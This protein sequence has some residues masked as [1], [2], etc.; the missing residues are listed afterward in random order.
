M[1]RKGFNLT[2]GK[3]GCSIEQEP[4]IPKVSDMAHMLVQ[5]YQAKVL[6]VALCLVKTGECAAEIAIA[7]D[8]AKGNLLKYIKTLEDEHDKTLCNSGH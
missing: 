8:M 7:A 2:V 5:T 4:V 6:D 3:Q 1:K